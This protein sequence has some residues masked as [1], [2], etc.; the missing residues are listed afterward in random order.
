MKH[1]KTALSFVVGIC[2]FV[3]MFYEFGAVL[4]LVYDFL[5]LLFKSEF[6]LRKLIAPASFILSF[7][8]GLSYG[9]ILIDAVWDRFYKKDFN[10]KLHNTKVL[11]FILFIVVFF[12]VLFVFSN[13]LNL[14]SDVRTNDFLITLFSVLTS[15]FINLFIWFFIAIYKRLFNR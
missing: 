15:A 8:L 9:F 11:K 14:D 13:G 6:A 12:L 5:V 4:N 2:L 7:Y 3:M 10:A 1:L